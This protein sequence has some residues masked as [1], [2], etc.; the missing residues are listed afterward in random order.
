MTRF[1]K[2]RIDLEF[3]LFIRRHFDNPRKCRS[4]GQI[5][6]YM[7]ELR[8]LIKQYRDSFNYVPDKAYLLLSEYN[9]EQKQLIHRNFVEAYC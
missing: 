9:A 7:D 3:N 8:K 1:E 2:K 6:Y 4:I 5:R